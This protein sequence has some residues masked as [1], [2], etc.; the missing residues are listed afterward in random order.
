[1]SEKEE[2]VPDR[3][4]DIPVMEEDTEVEKATATVVG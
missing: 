3:D 4:V 2:I 1:M